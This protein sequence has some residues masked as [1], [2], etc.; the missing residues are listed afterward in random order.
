MT[1]EEFLNQYVKPVLGNPPPLQSKI[2]PL[3]QIKDVEFY[4]VNPIAEK[5]PVTILNYPKQETEKSNQSLAPLVIAIHE[6]NFVGGKEPCGQSG[7]AEMF[8]GKMLADKGYMVVCPT[9]TFTGS[10][11]P[12]NQWDTSNFYQKYPNWSAIGKDVS[13]ISWLLDS[14]A[15]SGFNVNHIALVGHSQGAI[16]SLFSAAL[17]TRVHTVIANAGFVNFKQDPNPERWS[18]SRW[19]KGLLS[20]PT[21]FTYAELVAAIAPRNALICNYLQDE[22]LVATFPNDEIQDIMNRFPSIDWA[23]FK[24]KHGWPL[25]VKQFAWSWLSKKFPTNYS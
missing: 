9:L 13:E 23:F 14:L 10:R 15:I 21:K 7:K 18:R 19:Y 11:Q 1:R 16:Y 5:V 3:I 20:I 4:Y 6:T 24:G 22:I 12:K 8:Y 17:D 2:S 25:N